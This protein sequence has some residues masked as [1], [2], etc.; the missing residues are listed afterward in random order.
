MNSKLQ[1]LLTKSTCISAD[2]VKRVVQST[3]TNANK[4]NQYLRSNSLR[5]T[6]RKLFYPSIPV[7]MRQTRDMVGYA[8]GSKCSLIFYRH[9]TFFYKQKGLQ[10][11]ITIFTISNKLIVYNVV[12]IFFFFF[13]TIGNELG[14]YNY[15]SFLCCCFCF[16]FNFIY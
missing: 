7:I 5:S 3:S 14:V 12:L 10:Y 2:K 15:V 13:F 6:E 1:T 16:Y 9:Y 8:S 11:Q 4:Q